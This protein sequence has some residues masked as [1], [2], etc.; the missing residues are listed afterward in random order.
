M[1]HGPGSGDPGFM[2]V[3]GLFFF[4]GFVLGCL[5]VVLVSLFSFFVCVCVYRRLY[6]CV[7]I[8]ITVRPGECVPARLAT[9]EEDD[10][11]HLLL[12]SLIWGSYLEEW[13]SFPWMLDRCKT[14]RQFPSKSVERV[15]LS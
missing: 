3:C 12:I 4:Y 7:C 1:C 9:P 13:L 14:S 8:R 6:V 2:S 10:G 5:C 15:S 11:T